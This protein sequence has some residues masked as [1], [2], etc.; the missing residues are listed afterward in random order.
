MV[1]LRAGSAGEFTSQQLLSG[2]GGMVA[3]A[4]VLMGHADPHV[5]CRLLYRLPVCTGGAGAG[6]PQVCDLPLQPHEWVP[7]RYDHRYVPLEGA[8]GAG[9]YTSLGPRLGLHRYYQPA[10]LVPGVRGPER[11]LG[12]VYNTRDHVCGRCG[13]ATA[14]TYGLARCNPKDGGGHRAVRGCLDRGVGGRAAARVPPAA[15]PPPHPQPRPPAPAQLPRAAEVPRPRRRSPPAGLIAGPSLH[16]S[17]RP[18]PHACRQGQSL[19]RQV[20]W[21]PPDQMRR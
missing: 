5:G 7:R 15:A 21:P 17:R 4:Q 14:E 9:G 8:A 13:V 19:G 2:H 16:A 18:R 11:K 12:G 20:T 1:V 3:H 10:H 6:T